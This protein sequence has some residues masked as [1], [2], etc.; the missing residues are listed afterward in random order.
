M[1]DESSMESPR[2]KTSDL[3]SKPA[4]GSMPWWV[5]EDDEDEHKKRKAARQSWMKPKI[6]EQEVKSQEPDAVDD[7]RRMCIL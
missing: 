4:H 1:Y 5:E 7:V 3:K 6:P 2:M